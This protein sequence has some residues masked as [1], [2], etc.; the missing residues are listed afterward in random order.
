MT[1]TIIATNTRIREAPPS[2]VFLPISTR[3]TKIPNSIIVEQVSFTGA[4]LT[5]RPFHVLVARIVVGNEISVFV[6]GIG[7]DER[8]VLVHT[9][10]CTFEGSIALGLPVDAAEVID[11]CIGVEGEC[12][13]HQFHWDKPAIAVIEAC[14]VRVDL[15]HVGSPFLEDIVELDLGH[16]VPLNDCALAFGDHVTDGGVDFLHGVVAANEYMV[17]AENNTAIYH[18]PPIFG[19][20]C[21]AIYSSSSSRVDT[22]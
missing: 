15:E 6:G 4:D 1:K 5:D 14:Q 19:S 12:H 2:H 16:L 17:T 13:R 8:A 20:F 22:K 21:C 10:H 3:A 7:V 11:H 9:V 18:I